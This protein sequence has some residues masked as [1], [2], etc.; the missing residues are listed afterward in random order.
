MG[1]I[2]NSSCILREGELLHQ[3]IQDLDGLRVLL[4]C[5]HDE[6]DVYFLVVVDWLIGLGG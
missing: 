5:R 6:W 3:I 2:L 4:C 1:S